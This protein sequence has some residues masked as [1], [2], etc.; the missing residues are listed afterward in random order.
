V[1]DKPVG[2]ALS[3]PDLNQVLKEIPSGRLLPFG[4]FK[5][6]RGKR[7]SAKKINRVRVITLGVLPEQRRTGLS[8]VFYVEAYHQAL[9]MN[10]MGQSEMS[11]ILEDNREMIG[12]IES[13]AKRKAYKTFRLY[14]K[15]I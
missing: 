9:K 15:T 7:P 3:L 8:A 1:N 13:F 5:L 14:D 11:W 6:L 10:L 2:F 4:I 12:A